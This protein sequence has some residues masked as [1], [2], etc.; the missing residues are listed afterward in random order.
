VLDFTVLRLIDNIRASR[1]AIRQLCDLLRARVST[2][3][4]RE[5]SAQ[6]LNHNR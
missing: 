3:C 4:P 5:P 6:M 2:V 1:T